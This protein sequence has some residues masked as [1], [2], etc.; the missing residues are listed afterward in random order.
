MSA[1]RRVSV[2]ILMALL[3]GS[4]AAGQLPN[5]TMNFAVDAQPLGDAL[6]AL[7]T[8][9][10]IRI[11]FYAETTEGLT[12]PAVT[13]AYTPEAALKMLLGSS[14]L[15][16]RVLDS[17]TVSVVA[18]DASGV[19]PDTTTQKQ[20]EEGTASARYGGEV[21]VAQDGGVGETEGQQEKA[22]MDGSKSEGALEEIV[23]TA[24]KREERLQDVPVPVTAVSAASL[25]DSNQMSIREY[26]NRIPGLSV[27]PVS[28]YGTTTVVIRG[29]TTGVSA[30]NSSIG[31]VVDDVPYSGAGQGNAGLIPEI[32]PT[33]LARL[34]VLRGPQGTLYG[35]NSFAG[36]I[37]YVTVDPSTKGF[38]ARVRGST[39]FVQ[40]SDETGY[41]FNGSVN[42][43]LNN[44]WAVRASGFTRRDP[45]YID[46]PLHRLKDVNGAKTSGG[47]LAGL[48]APS[49]NFSLK[50][51]ALYQDA[52]AFG[53]TEV[54]VSPAF[55]DLEQLGLPGAGGFHRKLQVYT[56]NL[57]AK[58]R[59]AD[60]TVVSAYSDI[61]STYDLDLNPTGAA[62]G[63]GALA[64]NFYPGAT[65][66]FGP[67]SVISHKLTEEARLVV[68]LG[69][70]IEWLLGGFYATDD[71]KIPQ[72]ATAR[73]FATGAE[74]GNF[75]DFL[76][77]TSFDELAAFT[78]VTFRLTDRFDV[79]LGGRQADY[80]LKYSVNQSGRLFNNIASIGPQ[81]HVKDSAFTYLVTPRL[82]VSP[83]LMLYA[84]MASGFRPGGVNPTIVAGIPPSFGPDKT[85]NYETGVKG[86]AF[87]GALSFDAALYYI[88][89]Q[90]VQITVRHPVVTTQYIAN[91]A[92]AKSQGIEFSVESHP[93]AGLTVAAWIAYNEAQLTENLPPTAVGLFGRAGDRLP[94]GA[95]W[96][97]NVSLE[98]TVPLTA[99]LAG[100]LGT[101][102]SYV[103]ER[104]G[105]FK[106]NALAPG[107]HFPSY[108]KVDLRAGV[109]RGSWELSAFA[110]NVTDKRAILDG[111]ADISPNFT[112]IQPR[113]VGLSLSKSFD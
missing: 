78:D 73:N 12:A 21:R 41:G 51:G 56:A 31:I 79:Q 6:N 75:A 81:F 113:T 103:G 60:L 22:S 107:A 13:G 69:E 59:A 11:V 57:S 28:A 47:R 74:A 97:G 37:K 20:G 67:Q 84:R 43:P 100:F 53:R 50:L 63:L 76:V 39:E 94:L 54:T 112:F 101:A 1:S 4:A 98:Q 24:Q 82:R 64:N 35:A 9:S 7:A 104:E 66:V 26:Y 48:W 111:D 80:E 109:R 23:V 95:R 36:L 32:D 5:K 10:G 25:I 55:G 83:D 110:N 86:R 61:D 49:Q 18:G 45:G 58:L 34:E 19:R 70:R 106:A 8:Q 2:G 62:T 38:S 44:T 99:D 16:Y 15:Q 33:D 85:Q 105:A 108:V 89:W 71:R 17:R 92:R 14:N 88:D 77:K 52:Q 96:S 65:G 29:L 40:S 72:H 93:L 42:V 90:D 91:A 46:D 30:S 87:G 68:P 27:A 3:A 102:V